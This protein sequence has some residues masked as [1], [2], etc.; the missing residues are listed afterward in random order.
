MKQYRFPTNV[1]QEC[2]SLWC[3][4]NN[5]ERWHCE[6]ERYLWPWIGSI[7]PKNKY[8]DKGNSQSN[9]IGKI[10]KFFYVFWC[11]EPLSP[12]RRVIG[13]YG[14][15]SYWCIKPYVEDLIFESFKRNW[16]APFE[17]TGNTSWLQSFLYPC[18]GDNTCSVCPFSIVDSFVHPFF[19]SWSQLEKSIQQ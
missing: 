19:E 3:P 9:Q 11:F 1:L 12:I 8:T 6:M 18:F 17:I 7:G 16:C 13:S 15:I 4:T 10:S 14:Q 2:S 5:L